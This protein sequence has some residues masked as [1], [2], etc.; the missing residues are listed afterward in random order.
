MMRPGMRGV[1]GET[2]NIPNWE[3]SIRRI[4]ATRPWYPPRRVPA[5]Q[6]FSYGFLCGELVHRVTGTS[7]QEFF[8][9]NFAHPLGL[10]R[11]TFGLPRSAWGERSS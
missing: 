3:K 9:D 1:L 8:D 10:T 5:Y 4:E 2:W 6:F 7:I 11:T